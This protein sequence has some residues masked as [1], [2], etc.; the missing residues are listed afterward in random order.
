MNPKDHQ[1]FPRKEMEHILK[2]EISRTPIRDPKE[3]KVI[4]IIR[5]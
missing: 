1:T 5:T 2:L 4:G 3:V